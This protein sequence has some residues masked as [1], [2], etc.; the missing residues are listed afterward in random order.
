MIGD[1]LK[2]LLTRDRE[3]VLEQEGDEVE[4]PGGFGQELPRETANISHRG[5]DRIGR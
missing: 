2:D 5:E 3:A 4:P 1:G